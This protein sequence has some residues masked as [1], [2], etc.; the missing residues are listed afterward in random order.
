MEK[1]YPSDAGKMLLTIEARIGELSLAA[2]RASPSK[3]LPES[4]RQIEVL[5]RDIPQC[6]YDQLHYTVVGR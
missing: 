3:G 1:K 5:F 6:A 2:P 4:I